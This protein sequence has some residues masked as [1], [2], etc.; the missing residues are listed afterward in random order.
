MINEVEIINMPGGNG[1]ALVLAEHDK[2]DDVS[3]VLCLH[4]GIKGNQE[5]VV[6]LS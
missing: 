2:Q 4:T 5:Y 6:W 3:L 1:T